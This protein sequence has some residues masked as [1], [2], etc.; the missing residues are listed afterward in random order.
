MIVVVVE[1]HGELL[2]GAGSDLFC[3]HG[4]VGLAGI[5][6][7]FADLGFGFFLFAQTFGGGGGFGG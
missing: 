2:V 4:S 7:G 6:D 1:G 5:V 3:C